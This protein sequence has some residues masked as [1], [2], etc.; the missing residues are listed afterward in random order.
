MLR[1]L[2]AALVLAIALPGCGA[3]KN[4]AINL[5]E[6]FGYEKREQL[7]DA[8]K[9]SRDE[10]QE[11]KKQFATALDEFMAVTNA[12]PSELENRYRRLSSRYEKAESQAQ[13]VRDEIAHTER[14]ATLVFKEWQDELAQYS[15]PD[16]R[17]QSEVM[18]HDTRSQY[19]RLISTM[20]GAAAKMDPVLAAFKDQVLFLKHNL[21]A[22]EDYAAPWRL[23]RCL[24]VFRSVPSRSL[25]CTH[26][27]TRGYV[28]THAGSP[29]RS[30][31]VDA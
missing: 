16:L 28:R 2:F 14:V 25:A 4:A 17:R 27:R 18:M 26:S 8:V 15:S 11:A 21:T 23:F 19:E 9:D 31:L 24:M 29:L 10:Q 3:A 20:K 30:P 13:A 7:V 5:K 22:R 12:K 6:K 1:T